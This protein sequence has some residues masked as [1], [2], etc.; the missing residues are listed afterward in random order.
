LENLKGWVLKGFLRF[1]G[2]FDCYSKCEILG[3]LFLWDILVL[4]KEEIFLR[5]F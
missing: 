3:K 2:I 4:W 1:Y 5:V